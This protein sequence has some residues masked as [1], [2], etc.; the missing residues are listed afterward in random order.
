MIIRVVRK[1][2]WG[3]SLKRDAGHVSAS[4]SQKQDREERGDG[5]GNP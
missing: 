1:R 3:K 4:E 2:F 5:W